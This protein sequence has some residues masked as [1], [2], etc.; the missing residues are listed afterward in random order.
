M[1]LSRHSRQRKPGEWL[2]IE[3]METGDME[4]QWM[5]MN[6]NEWKSMKWNEME[7]NV[8]ICVV[9]QASC[10][11]CPKHHVVPSDPHRPRIE[12]LPVWFWSAASGV[13][14]LRRT[15]P[16]WTTVN[17]S[18]SE[19]VEVAWGVPTWRTGFETAAVK[20]FQETNVIKRDQTWSNVI[21]RDQT[22]SNVSGYRRDWTVRLKCTL[23]SVSSVS[24]WRLIHRA[25]FRPS[26]ALRSAN[27]NWNILKTWKRNWNP[28]RPQ[29]TNRSAHLLRL[30]VAFS[31]QPRSSTPLRRSPLAASHGCP[32]QGVWRHV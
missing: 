8:Q 26:V 25:C 13:R 32:R 19:G 22:W 21:K 28:N 2:Q 29:S 4:W 5:T 23:W 14:F 7:W 12:L 24:M 31:W 20:T 10:T 6:N 9:Q 18:P 17:Q 1:P 16:L 15:H 11:S 27:L 30:R 3:S